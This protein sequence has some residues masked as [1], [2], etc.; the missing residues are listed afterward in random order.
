[1]DKEVK[2]ATRVSFGEELKELGEKNEKIVV[3]DAD[4]S[5]AT[6]TNIF[7]KAFPDRFFDMGIAENNMIGVASGLSTCG[8]IPFAASIAVF[9][10]GRS[11]DQLRASVA[12]PNLNVKVVGSHYGLTVGEDGATHQM[13][14]DISLIRGLPNFKIFS[15]SD[16]LSTKWAVREAVKI[17]G[18]VY[19]RVCRLATPV[20][21]DESQKFEFGKAI[22]FGDGEDATVF[23]TGDMVCKALE[24]KELLEK[25]NI[26]IRVVDFHTI[27]PIDRE[28]I[29]K[30]AEETK[31]LI[32]IEDHSIYGGLGDAI[33]DVLISEYPK[34]LIKM[35]VKDQFGHSGKAE[36]VLKYYGLT[37][38]KII[39][40]VKT[41]QKNV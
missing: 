13:L 39:E 41:N 32:S 34:K 25:E 16:D 1:M 10:T 27:K 3:L 11:Y 19:I 30:C 15:P 18:P 23:A 33:S 4:L 17:T 35:G 7:A 26:N 37:T 9:S 8:K 6:K 40:N 36:D 21:Y 2:K 22:C 5:G 31:N 24:A 14:E 38:E 28:M 29:L 20:I 12:Y